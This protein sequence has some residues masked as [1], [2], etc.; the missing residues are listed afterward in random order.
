VHTL[1]P[2][3]RSIDH[4]PRQDERANVLKRAKIMFGGAVLD[5]TVLDVSSSGARLLL[6]TPASLSGE[7]A[8]HMPGG[9]IHAA[10]LSWLRG[11]EIGLEFIGGPKLALAAARLASES[12]QALRGIA[13]KRILDS[14]RDHRYFDDPVLADAARAL[15][16]AH[17]ALLNALQDRMLGSVEG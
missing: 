9:I 10:R 2:D 6:G 7:F 16:D 14:L 15:A 4:Y 1:I 3:P 8:L 5:C 17:A 13:P 12:V 11:R